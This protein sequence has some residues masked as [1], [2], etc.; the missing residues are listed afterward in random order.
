LQSRSSTNIGRAGV[1]AI[2]EPYEQEGLEE[3]DD[4]EEEEDEL[5]EEQFM[6]H[7]QSKQRTSVSA[8]AYGDWN[9]ITAFSPVVIPKSE[10]QS[11]KLREVLQQCIL[12]ETLDS[13]SLDIIVGAMAERTVD[14]GERIINEGE[15]GDV[16][17]VIEQG[18]CDCFKQF[19]G[20]EEPVKHCSA[21]DY[22][23]E[24]ALLY[25]CP[26]AASV[27]ARETSHIW[28]LDSATFNHVVRDASI[29]KREKYEAFLSQ[30]PLLGA[31][32]H[33][34]RAQLA[35]ALK[36]QVVTAGTTVLRQGDEGKMFYIV[37]DGQLVATK[38]E[39]GGPEQEVLQYQRGGY[40][41]EL[42]LLGTDDA[43]AATVVAQ[44]DAKLLCVDRNMFERLLGPLKDVMK[45]KA[46][47]EYT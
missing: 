7:M 47:D 15:T 40:F 33:Y 22:F 3:D 19:D 44:T 27:V 43:R 26:R 38:S 37:E 45:Q 1:M 39:E 6:R 31:L 16:M 32:G 9:Q 29:T 46:L 17:F 36:T 13:E 28:Q 14:A 11:A 2:P 41:G 4:D 21:G 10:E 18:S 42:A 25:N 12:F 35:D 30:I 23:G 20:H 34:E 24:L 5:D 8:E